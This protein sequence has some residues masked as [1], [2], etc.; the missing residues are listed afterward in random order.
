MSN[1]D[2][3]ILITDTSVLINFLNINRIDLLS[4]YPGSF[5]IT[6]DVVYEITSDFS[7][8][9]ALLEDSI[10]KKIIT[11]IS[12]SSHEEL[13]LFSELINEKRLGPG[14]CSAIACAI[15]RKYIL[16]ID[17]V[18]ARKQALIKD[19]KLC[20]VNTQEIIV[21][22]IRNQS[23]TMEQADSI[24]EIWEVKYRFSLK[25]KSFSEVI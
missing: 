10:N 22:L 9:Q 5:Y 23:L 7:H 24:K 25:I 13:E 14:E 4:L 8:Q 18:R 1:S 19:D 2:K 12:V 11:V 17:D 3:N 20:L 6:D 16:A 21:S 15:S